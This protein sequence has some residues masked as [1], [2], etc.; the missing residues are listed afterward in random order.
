MLV[1][2]E[3]R[4]AGDVAIA[5]AADGDTLTIDLGEVTFLDS[6]GIGALVGISNAAKDNAIPLVLRAVPDRI[7]KLLAITGL[8]DVFTIEP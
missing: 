1:S 5:Q 7:T 8:D 2:A 3:V 6:T 4:E